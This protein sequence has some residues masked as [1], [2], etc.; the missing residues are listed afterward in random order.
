MTITLSK[1]PSP[2]SLY[3]QAAGSARRRPG[4]QIE[5]PRLSVR[6][7]NFRANPAQLAGYNKVC[8][9]ADAGTLPITFPQVMAT[10]LQMYLMIQPQFPLP[11][12]GLVHL[13]NSIVQTRPLRADESFTVDVSLGEARSVRSGLEFDVVTEYLAE[14]TVVY[15]AL[16]TVLH[17]IAGPRGGK[18]KPE[19]LDAELV[20]YRNF[21]VPADIGRRYAMVGKDFNPI[22]LTAASARLFG[23]KRAIAHGMWSLARC[24][25]LLQEG[26]STSPCELQVQFKQPLFLPGKVAL[27]FRD[28]GGQTQFTLLA[29][30][31]DKVHLA[32]SLR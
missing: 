18:S 7:D 30:A 2:L 20:E 9:F 1:L 29:R 3:A 32:G 6:I 15:R 22:H 11:L 8:G 26:R 19:P 16:M 14:E 24:A 27:K 5:I 21:D 28:T 12:L 17:R 23:F 25:A 13:R 31:S 10:G 4:A